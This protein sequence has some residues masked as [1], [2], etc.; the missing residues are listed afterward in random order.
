LIAIT[1][2]M[3]RSVKNRRQFLIA[4]TTAMHRSVKNRR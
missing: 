1:T 4:I 2:A 3:H